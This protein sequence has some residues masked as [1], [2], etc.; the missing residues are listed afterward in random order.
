M[1][2]QNI[3]KY[4]VKN[5][6]R[7]PY[8]GLITTEDLFDLDVRALDSIFKTLK[9]EQKN[10]SEE[11]LIDSKSS[12]DKELEIKIA[13]VTEIVSD[14]LEAAEKAKRAAEKREKKQKILNIIDIKQN[15]ALQNMSVA[16]LTKLLAEDEDEE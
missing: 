6:L 11:S 2:T 16:E 13:I 3:Y 8:K 10:A 15:E 1:T 4:A 7:F 9:K 14:K 5:A 12:A